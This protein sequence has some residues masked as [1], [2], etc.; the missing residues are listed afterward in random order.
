[1][2]NNELQSSRWDE[3]CVRAPNP[4]LKLRAIVNSAAGARHRRR[5]FLYQAPEGV[6]ALKKTL[7]YFVYL[8]QVRFIPKR[9]GQR[10]A[11]PRYSR[12][13]VGATWCPLRWR[14]FLY[15]PPAG[16]LALKKKRGPGR[17]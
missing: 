10:I 11:N 14:F 13:P 17:G 6:H 15:Q 7:L 12:M 1:M 8:E 16:V 3:L 2:D 4:Q 5:F 9:D